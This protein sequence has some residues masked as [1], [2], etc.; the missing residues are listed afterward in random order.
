M[1]ST[2]V[3][4]VKYLPFSTQ[5]SSCKIQ[6]STAIGYGIPSVINLD[7]THICPKLFGIKSATMGSKSCNG[8]NSQ[9]FRK[10]LSLLGDFEEAA[11]ENCGVVWQNPEISPTQGLFS[12]IFELDFHMT[13]EDP[14]SSSEWGDCGGRSHMGTLVHLPTSLITG[15]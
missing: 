12:N 15:S 3:E 1:N 10:I 9:F 6:W 11:M 13:E 14:R 4:Y 8:P 2:F 7:V 5:N